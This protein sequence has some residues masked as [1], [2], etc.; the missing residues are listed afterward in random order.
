MKDAK[1]HNLSA[2][3]KGNK[4][5][6]NN[7]PFTYDEIQEGIKKLPEV[8]SSNNYDSPKPARKTHSEP[9]TPSAQLNEAQ[10][11]RQLQIN[12]NPDQPKPQDSKPKPISQN[13]QGLATRKK[14]E[15]TPNNLQG[16]KK[17]L[18]YSTRASQ[19]QIN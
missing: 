8:L 11:D 15:S 5:V 17:N 14:S 13:N 7:E 2:Y 4:I 1:T 16:V 9:S 18:P 19:K 6:I 10:L 12:S 3:I